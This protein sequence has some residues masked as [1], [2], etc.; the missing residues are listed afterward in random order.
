MKKIVLLLFLGTYSLLLADTTPKP[1]SKQIS[2]LIKNYI[3]T[4]K[5]PLLVGIDTRD[6]SEDYSCSNVKIS[7][8]KVLKVGRTGSTYYRQ[9][10]QYIN[11]EFNVKFKL[12][13]SCK[14]NK[15]FMTNYYKVKEY[16][17]DIRKYNKWKTGKKPIKP[18]E[19]NLR[20]R[21]PYKN[22]PYEALIGTDKYG[23]WIV[24]S[25][26]TFKKEDRNYK[27][28]NRNYLK[29]LYNS[30][31][32]SEVAVIQNKRNKIQKAE[33]DRKKRYNKLG[34]EIQ[35]RIVIEQ[36]NRGSIKSRVAVVKS[37]MRTTEDF[38]NYR[39][40]EKMCKK[41]N[42]HSCYGYVSHCYTENGV[43]RC[44]SSE[45]S[46][47]SFENFYL[48]LINAQS[49]YS[50]KIVK[51]LDQGFKGG[52]RSHD[53]IAKFTKVFNRLMQKHPNIQ[54]KYN[55]KSR[56]YKNKF[57]DYLYYQES[58]EAREIVLKEFAKKL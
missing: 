2:K 26:S 17:R 56:K 42:W 24:Y 13:G 19:K 20:G 46:L 40:L 36:K 58:D 18:V 15:P 51:R 4:K 10:G 1:S 38:K 14:I 28:K 44:P 39:E 5:T 50:G 48:P 9:S 29:K 34:K 47:Q 21:L 33:I 3:I 35:Q 32:G 52:V 45:V 54:T 41:N 22:I 16:K 23:D 6:N 49:H 12:S 25:I 8:L 43:K 57:W 30:R 37:H 53:D 11:S 7:S 31:F 55:L 27:D